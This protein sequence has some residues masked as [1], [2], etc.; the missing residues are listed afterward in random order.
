M[1]NETNI[2]KATCKKLGITQKQLA[3]D[4]GVA[5]NTVSQWSRGV[6][7]T[8]KWAI[9]MF[10]LMIK[11]KKYDDAKQIFCDSDTE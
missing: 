3:E 8:P 5:E 2:V 7:D 6:I 1:D 4:M 10:E 9:N 11:A